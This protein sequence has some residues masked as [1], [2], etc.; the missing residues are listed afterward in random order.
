MDFYC[1][2]RINIRNIKP[3][4]SG[5]K[6]VES[7]PSLREFRGKLDLAQI[8]SVD[9]QIMYFRNLSPNIIAVYLFFFVLLLQ[10]VS[11]LT[12]LL[13][14]YADYIRPHEESI[15]KSIVNLLVTCTD[16]VTIRKVIP[17]FIFPFCH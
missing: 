15:C 5:H 1:T 17:L 6:E 11:F 7:Y 4:F 13:K 3:L 12:Y 14:S 9:D 8:L 2:S 16:S 10:T